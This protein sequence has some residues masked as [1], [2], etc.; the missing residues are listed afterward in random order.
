MPPSLP[1][2][3][4]ASGRWAQ[5]VVLIPLFPRFE[6]F[7]HYPMSLSVPESPELQELQP[8]A[9]RC[10]SFSAFGSV[11]EGPLPCLDLGAV[12]ATVRRAL[13]E[14]IH[15]T[16]HILQENRKVPSWPQFQ[17]RRSQTALWGVPPALEEKL[18]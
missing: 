18:G 16:A 13:L 6:L 5:G 10:F 1:Q 15:V 11:G 12:A 8:A 9:G 14:P 2:P 4:A 7:W 17:S 3:S